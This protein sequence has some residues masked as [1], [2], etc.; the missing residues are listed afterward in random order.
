MTIPAWHEKPVDKKHNRKGFDCGQ[1]DL[2]NFIA[3]YARQSHDNGVAKSYCAVDAADGITILGF[4][5]ISPTKVDID[6]VPLA[7]RPAAGGNHPVGGFLL[8]RLAVAKAYQGKGLGGHLLILAV[9]RCARA[10]KEIGGTALMIDAKDEA[11]V[12]WYKSYGAMPLN[13]HPFFLILTYAEFNKARIK[14]GLLPI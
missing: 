6:Q 2:N 8:C 10:S 13:D 7:A 4:Y 11:G 12:A 1:V 9:E 3:K 5:T 14:A